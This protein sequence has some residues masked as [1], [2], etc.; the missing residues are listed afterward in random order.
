[1]YSAAIFSQV[2]AEWN[3]EGQD[4]AFSYVRLLDQVPIVVF[5]DKRQ[6]TI[7]GFFKH[8]SAYMH[9]CFLGFQPAQFLTGLTGFINSG[10]IDGL[11]LKPAVTGW[12]F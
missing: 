12:F 6:A 3:A 9:H 10:P 7:T 8:R 2:M 1:M 4:E 5:G 11:Y